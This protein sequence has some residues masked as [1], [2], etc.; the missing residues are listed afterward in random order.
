MRKSEDAERKNYKEQDKNR[1]GEVCKECGSIFFNK[2]TLYFHCALT[3]N[4][5]EHLCPKCF[6]VYALIE[7]HINKCKAPLK[8]IKDDNERHKLILSKKKSKNKEIILRSPNKFLKTKRK[9]DSNNN[10]NGLVSDAKELIHQ[11]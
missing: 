1:K 10:K 8:K 11:K 7:K 9:N 5:N 6:G 4:D 2:Y 3:H